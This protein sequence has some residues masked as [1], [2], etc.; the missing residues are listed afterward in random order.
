MQ[1]E[2]CGEAAEYRI[3][4]SKSVKMH[5]CGQCR[6]SELN[7]TEFAASQKR[8]TPQAPKVS[9]GP[10][11]QSRLDSDPRQEHPSD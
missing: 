4:L 2:L 9:E 8:A 1:C 3:H 7:L 5:V 10:A 11:R 6:K